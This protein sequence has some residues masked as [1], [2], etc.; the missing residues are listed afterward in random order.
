MDLLA[1]SLKERLWHKLRHDLQS[2]IPQIQHNDLLM[3]CTCGRFLPHDD[4]NLEH[5]IPQQA[6]ADDPPEIKANPETTA[7]TRSGNILLCRKPLLVNGRKK[8]NNGCN[9]WK[10]RFY[11]GRT[12]ELIN[13]RIFNDPYKKV[14]NEH[15]IAALCT[16]YLAM[17][18]E[19][20]YQVALTPS[21]VLMRR[22]FFSPSKFHREIPHG[23][24]MIL[25]APPPP[26]SENDIPIWSH[27][28]SFTINRNSCNVRFRT[29]SLSVPISRDPRLPIAQSLVFA[30][31]KYKLRPDFSTVFH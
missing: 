27:P 18:L 6:L 17:V 28:F 24:Q 10:G 3:C 4:F 14:A 7:N 21:G 11:D 30:P 20:G 15:I 29:M 9:G 2:Y 31:S 16:A 26:Y 12:R 22:Q 5:I 1:A 23:S 13:A 19:F 8:H 25:A